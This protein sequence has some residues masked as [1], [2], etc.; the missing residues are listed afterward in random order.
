MKFF[1][2]FAL[3][4]GAV[5]CGAVSGNALD[6]DKTF[7]TITKAA[8]DSTS[9]AAAVFGIV[10]TVSEFSPPAPTLAHDGDSPVDEPPDEEDVKED[11][12]YHVCE[13]TSGSPLSKD[14]Q[15]AANRLKVEGDNECRQDNPGGSMCHTKRKYQSASIAVCGDFWWGIQCEWVA[16]AAEQLIQKC[17]KRID[18]QSRVGGY[19]V[20]DKHLKAVLVHN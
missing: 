14:V 3:L 2:S 9:S 13:T 11:T 15:V 20:F 4:A 6:T 19:F 17:T 7:T 8:S 10:V 16:G 18:G 5:L 12:N 1:N